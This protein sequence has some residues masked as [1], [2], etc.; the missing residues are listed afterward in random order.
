[1]NPRFL[2]LKDLQPKEKTGVRERTAKRKELWLITEGYR[3]YST[4]Y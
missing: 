2:F 1:M 3:S 4:L